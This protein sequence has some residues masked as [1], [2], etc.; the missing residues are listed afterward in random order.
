M[1]N[2]YSNAGDSA[3]IL[4]FKKGDLI[5]LYEDNGEVFINTKWCYG[6]CMRTQQRGDFPAECVYILPAIT[7]PPPE[8]LVDNQFFC[9][10]CSD[11]ALTFVSALHH[12]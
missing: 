9:Y 4:N 12:R 11:Y 1:K 6:Q 8:I 10:S 3:L 2:V 7:R 5:E